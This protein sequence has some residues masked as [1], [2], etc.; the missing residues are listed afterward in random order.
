[1]ARFPKKGTEHKMCVLVFSKT[2]VWNIS[3]SKQKQAR[4]D[5][6]N[7]YCS[8]CKV[9]VIHIRFQLNFKFLDS[10]SK[11]SS[12]KFHENPSSGSRDV[13]CD[14]KDG[15]TDM[16]KLIVVFRKFANEPKYGRHGFI[17]R[18]NI[19]YQITTSST[20]VPCHHLQPTGYCTYRTRFT[21]K[22]L[23]SIHTVYCN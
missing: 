21:I 14:R 11:K 6:K 1:M 20:Y 23:H 19:Y 4:Y 17:C 22:T 9:P 8:T 18:E 13:P 10:F 2:F 5:K 3:H 7:V 16:T 12:I 15:R